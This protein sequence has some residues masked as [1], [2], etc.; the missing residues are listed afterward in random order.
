MPAWMHDRAEHILAKNPSMPKSEAFAIAS[1]QTHA[2][3]KGPKGW[4]TA[5]GKATAKKKYDTP[6]NDEHR[7]NPGGLESPKMEKK[8]AGLLEVVK[9]AMLDELQKIITGE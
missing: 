4:G 8:E 2:L 1:Q 7:A 9:T 5:E 6:K 3:G